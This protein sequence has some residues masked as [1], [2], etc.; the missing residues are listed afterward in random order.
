MSEKID[1]ELDNVDPSIELSQMKDE[2]YIR[3]Y[4]DI[5]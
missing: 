1:R 3:E 4:S 2:H 5:E